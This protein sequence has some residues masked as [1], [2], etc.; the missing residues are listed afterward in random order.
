MWATR[1]GS[2]FTV[3]LAVGL[4][5]A[6]GAMLRWALSYW[7]NRVWDVMPTGTLLCNL[8]GAFV[9]GLVTAYLAL[10]PAL[11]AWVRL[12][13]VTGL[14]GGLTTFSTFSMENVTLMTAGAWGRAFCHAAAHLLGSFAMTGAG[15]ALMKALLKG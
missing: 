7:F 10:H 13:A 6:L 11:P 5:A 15:F 2:F 14:L 1:D 9:I 4:G 3:L 12:F 8:V